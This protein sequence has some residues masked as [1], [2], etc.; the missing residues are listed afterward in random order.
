MSWILR[1]IAIDGAA[2]VTDGNEGDDP[3]E[4]KIDDSANEKADQ[5]GKR[6]EYGTDQSD[7][8]SNLA[9]KILLKIK[10]ATA[11]DS[12]GFHSPIPFREFLRG[13]IV[14]PAR[15][16]DNFRDLGY[17][18]FVSLSAIPTGILHF[19]KP[20][21]IPDEPS[22]S[23]PLDIPPCM[24]ELIADSKS[25]SS[26][27][28]NL[29]NMHTCTYPLKTHYEWDPPKASNLR[30]TWRGDKIRVISARKATRS[31]QQYYEELMKK[32]Y[33]FSKGKRGPIES[34]PKGK[35]RITI[36]IDDDVLDWFR[37]QVD[38]AGGGNYQTLMNLA[39]RDYIKKEKEP[40]EETIRRVLREELATK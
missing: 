18:D 31:E 5:T 13:A 7:A 11:T 30:Y 23:P 1:K 4:D 33:D 38:R 25:G 22:T 3:V 28:R 16:A 2:P 35:T 26:S 39:L 37:N 9:V 10:I 17:I 14:L 24:Y 34:I 27:E 15:I 20:K 36:R 19:H 12:T 21:I 8:T 6:S 29:D 40:L 32:E